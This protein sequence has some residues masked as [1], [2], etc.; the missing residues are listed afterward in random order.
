MHADVLV[1]GAG[2]AGASV[3]LRLAEAG[4]RVAVLCATPLDTS[5]SAQALGG[6][7][8]A[9]APDD[10]PA[11]HLEDTLGAGAGLVREAAARMTVEAAP[12]AIAW[13]VSRGVTFDRAQDMLD[14]AQEGGHRR[15]RIVHAADATGRV[16]MAAL[17]ERLATHP[18]V[19]L[20]RDHVA[21][22]LIVAVSASGRTICNGA[23]VYDAQAGRIITL[24]ATHVVLATGGASGAF[25]ISTNSTRPVGDGIALAWRAGCRIAN[26]EMVQ[27]HPT[28]LRHPQSDGWLVTEAIRGD[29]GQLRLPN[30]ERFMF[31]HDPRGELAP[32][33]VVAR[34]IHAEMRSH[35]LDSVWL[36]I[37]HLDATRI[38][39]RFPNTLA[40]CAALG[41]DITRAPMPVAPAAHYTCGGVVTG[42]S[43]DTDIAGLYAV[44]EVA[45]TGLHGA[46]RLASNSLLEGLVFGA[47]AAADILATPASPAGLPDTSLTDTPQRLPARTPAAARREAQRLAA[48]IRRILSREAGIVRSDTGLAGAV[49]GLGE[50]QHRVE[51]LCARHAPDRRLLALRNLACVAGLIAQSAALRKESRG[52]H[53]NTDHPHRHPEALDIVLRSP[54]EAIEGRRHAV[55]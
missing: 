41:I 19:R 15:R 3:A 2:I 54:R 21:A 25:E 37:S 8:A 40:H 11:L 32:R 44:G 28:A 24:S 9:L 51:T 20:L 12:S 4:R 36:D 5:A 33:D 45:W 49:A 55:G 47:A 52:A 50:L 46:N 48:G 29:G 34:A 10:S 13:L 30:G 39:T 17:A 43:G 6:I 22:E 16:V 42:A 7:A 53:F 14:L 38:R 27:F 31:R 1:V 35:R 26:M 18:R 23:R